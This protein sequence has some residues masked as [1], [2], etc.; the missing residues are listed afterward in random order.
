MEASGRYRAANLHECVTQC[1]LSMDRRD[2]LIQ[3]LL[4]NLDRRDRVC[5]ANLALG[6]YKAQ[7]FLYF[8]DLA[9]F[10]VEICLVYDGFIG[11]TIV[12]AFQGRKAS[13]GR[14]QYVYSIQT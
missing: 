11:R 12:P 13:A 3:V 9:L 14:K 8:T 2:A 10:G 6:A 5:F 1:L 7:H 4:E